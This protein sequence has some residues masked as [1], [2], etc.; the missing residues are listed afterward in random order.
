MADQLT[1][2][3]IAGRLLFPHKNI[4]IL[5]IQKPILPFFDFP[6]HKK[7]LAEYR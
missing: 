2:E 7:V 6:F 1:E 4:D 5:T 3:Q